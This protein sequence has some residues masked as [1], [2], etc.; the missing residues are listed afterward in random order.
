MRSFAL[1][2]LFLGLA[3]CSLAYAGDLDDAREPQP[4]VLVSDG[5]SNPEASS[6]L[7][8]AGAD[9]AALARGCG[10]YTN[11]VP[12]FC[13]DFDDGKPFS[14]A[15]DPNET[16]GMLS[17]DS[18]SYSGAKSML[19]SLET[20]ADCQYQRVFARFSP[21][22]LKSELETHARLRPTRSK[23]SSDGVAAYLT[24][25]LGQGD[26]ECTILLLLHSTG[27]TL[28][29]AS[30]L[31]QSRNNVNDALAL[32]GLPKEEQWTD[33]GIRVA[34]VAGKTQ[35]TTTFEDE[36]GIKTTT[37]HETT[38]CTPPRASLP[39]TYAVG[40]HCESGTVEARYDDVRVYWR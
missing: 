1:T 2:S 31:I 3:A 30:L 35:I 9:G 36:A 39:F 40:L 33:V 18:S 27:A 6:P 29:G 20:I 12:Q 32:D 23:Y 21:A 5:G 4:I 7:A 34:N 37:T 19:A 8:E 24:L 15:F 11:P 22:D 13:N 17:F 16:A 26:T 38:Q 10:A 28:D 14:A 25:Y